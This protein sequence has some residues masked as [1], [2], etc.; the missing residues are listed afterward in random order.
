[1]LPQALNDRHIAI[2][3]DNPDMLE[4]IKMEMAVYFHVSG[5][6][7][8]QTGLEGMKADMPSLLICDVMLPDTNGYDIV[9]QMRADEQLKNVPVIMLTA[10]DDEKHQIKGYEAG[11]DDYMVKPCNY[12]ILMARSIQ[13]IKWRDGNQ[14]DATA[15]SL[16]TSHHESAPSPS[17]SRL[18]SPLRP[19]SDSSTG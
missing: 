2:I 6:S 5:Y 3:E 17:P 18:S 11:A 10:L 13:L 19:I 7:D 4:Q 15:D 12:R 16:E 14:A 1:M 8:G 9:K